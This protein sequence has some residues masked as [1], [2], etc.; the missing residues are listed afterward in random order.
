MSLIVDNVCFT[1]KGQSMTGYI[2]P[3]Q[4]AEYKGVT[5]QAIYKAIERGLLPSVRVLD[6]VA[7]RLAD[8]EAYQP[9]SYNGIKRTV[10]RRGPGRSPKPDAAVSS[11]EPGAE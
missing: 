8:V 3:R 11:S 7:L 6:R 9:G 2:T 1:D 4:A 5:V 10:K